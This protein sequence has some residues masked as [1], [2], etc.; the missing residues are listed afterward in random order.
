MALPKS[1][2]FWE[3]LK[4]DVRWQETQIPLTKSDAIVTALEKVLP[5]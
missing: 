1:K 4:E 3:P 2:L 5:G